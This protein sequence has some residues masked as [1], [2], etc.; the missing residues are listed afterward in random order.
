MF[1]P[2]AGATD[3]E[4]FRDCNETP[5]SES[6]RP[7]VR[8]SVPASV[9]RPVVEPEEAA[10]RRRDRAESAADAGVSCCGDDDGVGS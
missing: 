5:F 6:V 9:C 7:Y 8:P 4:K 3:G 10:T 2:S 1:V